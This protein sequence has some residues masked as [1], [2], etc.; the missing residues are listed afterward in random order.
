M[1]VAP[2][3][4]FYLTSPLKAHF[5]CFKLLFSDLSSPLFGIRHYYLSISAKFL[6]ALFSSMRHFI[7][8][9]NG[10]LTVYLK[11]AEWFY[12]MFQ[13]PAGDSRQLQVLPAVWSHSG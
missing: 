12:E 11:W 5:L 8:W 13:V 9:K 2:A 1:G 4:W 10:K 7:V 3:P 6:L